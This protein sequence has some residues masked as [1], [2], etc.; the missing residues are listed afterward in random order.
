[1]I[2]GYIATYNDINQRQEDKEEIREAAQ[3]DFDAF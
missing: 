3:N 2:I 1:M